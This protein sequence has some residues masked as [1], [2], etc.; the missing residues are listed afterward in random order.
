M[1]D[2]PIG[3]QLLLQVFL[4]ALNAVFA[5]A[6]I[7]VISINDNKIAKLA[8]QGDKR[9][10]RLAKLTSQP[11]RFLSTIQV[12]ITLSG[13]LGSAFAADNFSTMLSEWIISLG[14]TISR[15]TLDTLSLIAITLILSYFTLVLGELVPKRV[16]MKKAEKL[17]LGMSGFISAMANL[18]RP[19]VALLTVSTNALLRL[20]KIDPNAED[21]EVTEEEIR[22]MV[23][24]GSEKGTIDN[25]EKEW[26]QNVFEFDD[27]TADEIA[28]HRTD[29]AILWMADNEEEWC[30]TIKE[31]RHSILPICDESVDDI[32]GVL[33]TKDYF[34]LNKID[35]EHILKD[36][37]SPAFFVPE[38]IRADIL[39]HRMR[40]TR[41]HFAII[42]DE[43]GGVTGVVTMNDLLEQL[44]GD[45]DDDA[46]QPVEFEIQ[47]LEENKWKILGSAEL[48][49][50]EKMLAI[51]LPTEEYDTFGGF[52]LGT[53][54]SI[55]DDG[56]EFTMEYDNLSIH[57]S[58]IKDHRVEVSFVTVTPK[59]TIVPDEEE[60][61]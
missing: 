26:I 34:R 9:A 20:L 19:I 13:F 42:L 45:L 58:K 2:V 14:V 31:S 1:N 50:V 47:Q 8:A 28:T 5:C 10:V 16:A 4:I 36:A 12:A 25:S 53:Y 11:A 43:Y 60:T 37:V 32:I 55:P 33:N 51:S 61:K 22:M 3:W 17:A 44:V 6:E 54:S 35:K 52:V 38:N 40:Q 59:V 57:V 46:N 21:D 48:D 49:E 27:I 39:F 29:L 24:V 7:A 41:N 23:D 56:T 30:K 18:F 15:P